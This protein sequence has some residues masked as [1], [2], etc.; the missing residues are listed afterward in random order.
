MT[1]DH[2]HTHVRTYLWQHPHT[3][4][5]CAYL[6]KLF[7][8][9]YHAK[10]ITRIIIHIGKKN[11]EKI[12]IYILNFSSRDWM[13]I[14]GVLS[15]SDFSPL[16]DNPVIEHICM[17]HVSNCVQIY[18]ARIQRSQ[19]QLKHENIHSS[20]TKCSELLPTLILN[21]WMKYAFILC[22]IVYCYTP[23]AFYNHV[24]GSL[25]NHHQCAA[26]T[27]WYKWWC[28]GCHR[29]TAPVR[30]PAIRWRRRGERVID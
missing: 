10:Q 22:F 30:S 19:Y 23:K 29:T 2:T 3:Y 13:E 21:E 16:T 4:Q 17:P 25:L 26:S 18:H 28:D 5:L 9:S 15:F 27:W 11:H 12:S 1:G 14:N 6:Y 8:S 20:K 24:G 7:L